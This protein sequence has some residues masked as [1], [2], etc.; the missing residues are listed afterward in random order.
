MLFLFSIGV[1]AQ[2]TYKV[3]GTK[4]VANTAIKKTAELSIYTIDIKDVTYP[5]YIT[6]TGKYYILRTSKKT[7]KEY[8]Q[9]ITIK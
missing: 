5:V 8:K 2:T 9:Y 1:T 7:G 3:E 4:L 6:S